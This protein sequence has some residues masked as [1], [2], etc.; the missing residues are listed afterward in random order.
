MK[1]NKMCYLDTELTEAIHEPLSP[2]LNRLLAEHINKD[3]LEGMSKAQ[4]ETE[5]E[6]NKL[7]AE[8][9]AKLREMRQNALK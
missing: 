7:E 9:K 4:L 1:T 3:A 6:C 8:V 5:L 2:L